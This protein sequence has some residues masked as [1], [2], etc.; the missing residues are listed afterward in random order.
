MVIRQW[1]VGM[2][3]QITSQLGLDDAV[4]TLNPDRYRRA[5]VVADRSCSLSG[6][7][8]EQADREP[9]SGAVVAVAAVAGHASGRLEPVEVPWLATSDL[10]GHWALT[11]PAART[12]VVTVTAPR[13]L[14]ETRE[15]TPPCG[16]SE[17]QVD[18][19]LHKGGGR[20]AG[21]V[22]GVHGEPVADAMISVRRVELDG[23][24]DARNRPWVTFTN[25]F[26]NFLLQ[27]GPGNYVFQARVSFAAVRER[28]LA[29][30]G[31]RVP[32]ALL[33]NPTLSTETDAA[34]A[35]MPPGYVSVSQRISIGSRRNFVVLRLAPSGSIS[36]R[37]LNRIDGTPV[38]RALVS[39][40]SAFVG[41]T[42][43]QRWSPTVVATDDNGN[44][45]LQ[46]VRPGPTL[47]NAT[48]G[49]LTS[50]HPTPVD[51]T[52]AAWVGGVE[53]WVERAHKI[54]GRVT[55]LGYP[56]L[57][58]RGQWVSATNSVASRVLT[59]H[60]PTDDRGMFEI[61]GLTP[62][63]YTVRAGT[64]TSRAV[65]AV[66]AGVDLSELEVEV[67]PS[68]KIRGRLVP[69][70]EGTVRLRQRFARLRH[71]LVAVPDLT[72]Q[73]VPGTGEFSFDDVAPGDSVLIA[74]ASNNLTGRVLLRIEDQENKEVAVQLERR[75]PIAG[76]LLDAPNGAV[77]LVAQSATEPEDLAASDHVPVRADGSF[78]FRD[79]SPGRYSLRAFRNGQPLALAL[80]TDGHYSDSA[81][82]EVLGGR[83]PAGIPE[84]EFSAELC[85]GMIVGTAV[86]PDGA[87]LP[88]A[89]V[90]ASALSDA[91][92]A[93]LDE[94]TLLPTESSEQVVMANAHGTFVFESLCS[95]NFELVASAKLGQWV[96][97]TIGVPN[98]AT[99]VRLQPTA[100]L[101]LKV[102]FRGV[103][104]SGYALYLTE[105]GD[106]TQRIQGSNTGSLV[107]HLVP[108]H[109][110][111]FF[112]ADD[113]YAATSV[114]LVPGS[115]AQQ[116]VNLVP[117]SLVR[118]RIVD[119]QGQPQAGA[120]VDVSFER[121]TQQQDATK[122]F[123]RLLKH[124]T[125]TDADGR[126][127]LAHVIKGSGR[128]FLTDS[129]GRALA[130]KNPSRTEL[131]TIDGSNPWIN[132]SVGNE[133]RLNI[134]TFEVQLAQ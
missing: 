6:L 120:A 17:L 94:E 87:P 24:I 110:E 5:Q 32:S 113:G 103:P 118:G 121:P 28:M 23:S 65:T 129:S 42:H 93:R 22:R 92:E 99:L 9:I 71:G 62:G 14:P 52:A 133:V 95:K 57:P 59:A 11:V 39:A 89:L 47:L 69:A 54:S 12:Y 13:F 61:V 119:A 7:V 125:V 75:A 101:D 79:L 35:P 124:R 81:A 8:L 131:G 56:E 117:W 30:A 45:A 44:F 26:G 21:D 123:F 18:I 122:R 106:R 111:L 128:I 105:P 114:D 72:A 83:K 10:A 115:T 63:S 97:R 1:L 46:D 34:T 91:N 50:H 36:G 130:A 73:A 102:D 127:E 77:S 78:L 82:H 41:S 27:L 98:T 49:E 33:E 108:G 58:V 64:R 66:V 116:T 16:S 40:D 25:D 100:G 19:V 15:L 55:Q 132:F 134:E 2:P 38:P 109:Y 74:E 53:V 67:D 90:Q 70:V 29:T 3:M 96:A 43:A 80:P 48:S 68:A 86:G 51:V 85:K 4:Q 104:V 84:I 60:H 31:R 126:F 88:S 20:V 112:E 37:V 107:S 76:R